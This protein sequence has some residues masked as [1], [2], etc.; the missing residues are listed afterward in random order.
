MSNRHILS[1]RCSRIL[2]A[3]KG[4]TEADSASRFEALKAVVLVRELAAF[5]ASAERMNQTLLA[6]HVDPQER[7][8]M[9]RT[10]LPHVFAWLAAEV[11]HE[12]KPSEE[13]H[14]AIRG[15]ENEVVF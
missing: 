15:A 7:I 13:N 6:H 1:K 10:K 2:E 3:Q 14:W 4:E 5:R 9:I 8:D 12:R 11:V